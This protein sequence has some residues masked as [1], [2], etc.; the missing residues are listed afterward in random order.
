V[1]DI[2]HEFVGSMG[3]LKYLTPIY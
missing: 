3:R 2:A 1:F